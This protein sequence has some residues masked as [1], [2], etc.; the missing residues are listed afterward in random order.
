MVPWLCLFVEVFSWG[1]LF[2]AGG[3]L[4][5]KFSIK[6][7]QNHNCTVLAMHWWKAEICPKK[8][9]RKKSTDSDYSGHCFFTWFHFSSL[10]VRTS[11][12]A[13]WWTNNSRRK[14]SLQTNYTTYFWLCPQSNNRH[15]LQV[16]RQS[17]AAHGL[18]TDC[19]HDTTAEP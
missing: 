12:S 2:G 1:E 14:S 8:K 5:L 18:P 19:P 13:G 6:I 7:F 3:Q 10:D 4:P 15:S 9:K 16:E 11:L 17:K